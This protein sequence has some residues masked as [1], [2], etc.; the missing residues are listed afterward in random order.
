MGGRNSAKV[1]RQCASNQNKTWQHD[2]GDA[3]G[4]C[5]PRHNPI[6]PVLQGQRSDLE[7]NLRFCLWT[8]FSKAHLG[9]SLWKTER[10][11]LACENFH[12]CDRKAK[13]K[14]EPSQKKRPLP[15]PLTLFVHLG[16]SVTC[17]L[18]CFMLLLGEGNGYHTEPTVFCM[19]T[20]SPAL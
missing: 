17:L 10:V 8:N 13:R 11:H 6:S 16:G 7:K 5:G 14:S 3:P 19:L 2:S 20:Q 9:L 4:P 12:F 18:S 15:S 1:T